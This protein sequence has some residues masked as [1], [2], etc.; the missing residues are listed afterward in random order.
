ML[1]PLLIALQFLTRLPVRLSGVPAPQALGRSLLWYPLVGGLLGALLTAAAQASLPP[2]LHAALLLSL[3]VG[4]TG[5]LHLDGL[6]DCADAWVGGHGDRERTLAIMKDPNAGPMG[7]TALVLVLLL[8]FAAL[9]ALLDAGR[10]ASLWLVPLL[11]RAAMPALFATTP[12]LRSV[13]LGSALASHLPRTPALLV[14]AASLALCAFAPSAGLHL[15]AVTV[16]VFVLIRRV[17]LQR[18]GGCTGDCAGAMLELIETS[19]LLA[20]ALA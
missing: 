13:G 15:A 9:H 3:W 8:K 5:A 19:A 6:A 1:Q 17:L 14:A 12:Y 18:L 2:L 7:V 10:T 11:A 4:F 16:L 20:L